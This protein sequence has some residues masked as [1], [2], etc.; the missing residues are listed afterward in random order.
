[1]G[2]GLAFSAQQ[3][4]LCR[5]RRR[6]GRIEV[7]QVE[8]APLPAGALAA[9]FGTPNLLDV[10]AC[11]AAL[12]GALVRA[13]VGRSAVAVALPDP[14]VRVRLLPQ[15]PRGGT[16]AET[17]RLVAWQLRDTLPFPPEQARVDCV[18]LGDGGG[19]LCLVG[20]EP[21][22]SQYEALL[23]RRHLLP[24]HVG[25]ASLALWN[26]VETAAVPGP[27]LEEPASRCA[28]FVEDGHAT[29]VAAWILAMKSYLERSNFG[30]QP[31]A[32]GRG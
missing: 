1:M 30:I 13:R 31:T 26:L 12:G 24:V 25:A 28:L 23:G 18:P 27:W 22:V 2:L 6:R 5:A 17:G 10:D 4:V 21:V 7:A 3:V 29:L 19:A 16:R 8:S 14:S 15:A 11:E 32:F 9:A 20:A